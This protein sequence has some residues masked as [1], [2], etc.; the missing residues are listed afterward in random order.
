MTVTIQLA[1]N[2]LDLLRSQAERQGVSVEEHVQ[3]IIDLYVDTTAGGPVEVAP[4]ADFRAAMRASF[5][6][7]AEL[8]RRLAR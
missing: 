3:A 1:N 5:H 8:Y 2:R 4:D 7:N 6:E